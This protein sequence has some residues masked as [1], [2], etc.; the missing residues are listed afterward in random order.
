MSHSTTHLVKHG[1]NYNTYIKETQLSLIQNKEN[2]KSYTN[3][4][5]NTN[6]PPSVKNFNTITCKG[7]NSNISLYESPSQIP[8]TSIQAYHQLP[9]R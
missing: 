6:Q 8:A 9:I 5:S 1:Q 4:P 2:A 3:L 7:Y